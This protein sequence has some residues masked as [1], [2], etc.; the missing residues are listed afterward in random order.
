M[1]VNSI[2]FFPKR[3]GKFGT[4]DSKQLP[5]TIGMNEEGGMNEVEF[6]ANAI[7]QQQTLYT[8]TIGLSSMSS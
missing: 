5:V 3:E 2:A 1:N 8:I 7:L 6:K 4:S